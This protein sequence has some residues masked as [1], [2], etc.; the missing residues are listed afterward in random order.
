MPPD[1]SVRF[2]CLGR[3]L[4]KGSD[5]TDLCF[6][7][8]GH[9]FLRLRS[10][11]M[12][13]TIAWLLLGLVGLCQ[14]APAQAPSF[15]KVEPGAVL[16]KQGA[17]LSAARFSKD[18]KLLATGG[19][20]GVLQIW[21]VSTG[22]IRWSVKGHQ[23][24][25][26]A[27]LFTPHTQQ[28][29]SAS[30]D[31]TIILWNLA[32]RAETARWGDFKLPIL[33]AAL[34]PD[35]TILLAGTGYLGK[36]GPEPDVKIID[37][38]QRK[39][40]GALAISHLQ[41][42]APD[43][44]GLDFAP[45]GKT[46]AIAPRGAGVQSWDLAKRNKLAGFVEPAGPGFTL[47]VAHAPDGLNVA[48][49][50]S[51]G[52]ISLLDARTWKKLGGMKDD[53]AITGLSFATDSRTLASASRAGTVKLWDVSTLEVPEPIV[54]RS[55]KSPARFGLF[56]PDGK[57]LAVG[58][59][60]GKLSLHVVSRGPGPAV[61]KNKEGPRTPAARPRLA[62]V[63]TERGTLLNLLDLAEAKISP[64]VQLVERRALDAVLAEQKLSLSG[65]VR[66][67]QVV[68]VGKLLG[69]EL[70][71]VVEAD[72]LKKEA[73]GLVIFDA[74]TG[75]RL[76]D[77]TLPAGSLDSAADA[78]S[79]AVR[80]ALD[81][82]QLQG[83]NLRTICLTTV[84]NADLPRSHDALCDLVGHLLERG[85]V[86]APNLALLERTRLDQVLKEQNLP[87]ESRLGQL[88]AS[89]VRIEL[90]VGKAPDGQGL[91]G[92]AFLV[93]NRGQDLGKAT[94]IVAEQDAAL[95]A[96]ALVA[97]LAKSLRAEPREVIVDRIREVLRLSAEAEFFQEHKDWSRSLKT[98]QA[99]SALK[100][101][102]VHLRA[103]LARALVETGRAIHGFRSD[104]TVFFGQS[105]P[106][107]EDLLRS[108]DLIV[109]C[110]ET[111]IDV[112]SSPQD[113]NTSA[114]AHSAW[115]N[116]ITYLDGLNTLKLD[117]EMAALRAKVQERNAVLQEL[118]HD[119]AV[120]EIKDKVKYEQYSAR[121]GYYF[122]FSSSRRA[123][124]TDEQFSK[125]ERNLARR[126][127]AVAEKWG[128]APLQ[129]TTLKL[130]FALLHVLEE[131]EDAGR[132]RKYRHFL[133][134]SEDPLILL[135]DRQAEFFQAVPKLA[136][137][138]KV[139][140]F[141]DF[142]VFAQK[143][144]LSARAKASAELRFNCYEAIINALEPL[145]G[146]V[147]TQEP[148]LQE[149]IALFRFMI[150]QKE[151][152]PPLV[153]ATLN[154]ARSSNPK[155][156]RQGEE[157]RF[158]VVND[159]LASLDSATFLTNIPAPTLIPV[160]RQRFKNIL[161][162]QRRNIVAKFPDLERKLVV[163]WPRVETLIDIA[164]PKVR[165]GYQSAGLVY[166]IKP[167]VHERHVYVVGVDRT[168]PTRT[169]PAESYLQLLR[170]SL[171]GHGKEA[172][173]KIAIKT[174][175]GTA[176]RA[177]DQVLSFK[178]KFAADACIHDGR[179]VLGTLERGIVI[180]SL[181]GKQVTH[182]HTGTGLPSDHVQA[183]TG[184]DG[185]IYAGVGEADKEGY[186]ITHDLKTGV[187]AVLASSRRKEALSPL[188]NTA[189][190][191][192]QACRADAK[193][194]RVL[195]FIYVGG[196]LEHLKSNGLWEID[197]KNGR[198]TQVANLYVLGT[199]T[200]HDLEWASPIVE[201]KLLLALHDATC[202]FDLSTHKVEKE[203]VTNPATNR[204]V[205]F[206]EPRLPHLIAVLKPG[207]K[208][209]QL[210][211]DAFFHEGRLWTGHPFGRI[212]LDGSDKEAF[213]NLRAGQLNRFRPWESFQI[214]G[215]QIL[216]ADQHALWLA[217][218]PRGK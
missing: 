174:N 214:A 91:R 210:R 8:V 119:R 34:S 162:D 12:K 122:F 129:P 76:W 51:A 70:F 67:D 99:A 128:E 10:D 133:V 127:L 172:L 138:D 35:G 52:W 63:S 32:T 216:I 69:A 59:D 126:W 200:R 100:P 90:E 92:T 93:N 6:L 25:V 114:T 24:P 109:Q 56:S 143:V 20:D 121:F 38:A 72:K 117:D 190:L 168:N 155:T 134:S 218:L 17:P 167:I 84:R 86:T 212:R 145:R 204:L 152:M 170:F 15:V 14:P 88:L 62:L 194:Q 37:L 11:V 176:S 112:E 156:D 77:A 195:A 5:L 113:N 188:D 87:T 196:S 68:Q 80:R 57:T 186:L 22:E 201:D 74:H 66:H 208:T 136:V 116:L 96:K 206:L 106:A 39:V 33:S 193:R 55:E 79:L 41:Q 97:E 184:L 111:L 158:I 163:P 132:A 115:Y 209:L 118:R 43:I 137:A 131:T 217:P 103:K 187:T 1:F 82:H 81:K 102:D 171:K 78:V 45:D 64:D 23:G 213:P 47:S 181:D 197:A 98:R 16:Q 142:R 205:S 104:S 159:A 42:R 65:F 107:K 125:Y 191:Y 123:G 148:V 207:N 50:Y 101:D 185:K 139:E 40:I 73:I 120:A 18:G 4:E 154:Q 215:D 178:W 179:F 144:L 3:N 153:S 19:M 177:I 173:G 61:A 149:L 48:V 26:Q 110:L 198:L 85:L 166:L 31:K 157:L 203:R 53:G 182:V 147:G 180:F 27:V 140:R 46:F 75:V 36:G 202:L 94:A 58:G 60:D 183:L 160:Q 169:T 105:G 141:R 165:P 199:S 135:Y 44:V 124:L 13:R 150:A 189:P 54:V 7:S 108:L 49:G 146:V 30:I 95:L 21:D 71:A 9:A 161:L 89:L 211:N 175:L 164:P 29:I 28:L 192:V 83:K 130:T 151:V 2:H